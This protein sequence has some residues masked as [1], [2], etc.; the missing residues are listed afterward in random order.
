MT[1]SILPFLG[2]ALALPAGSLAEE[3]HHEHVAPHGGTLVVLGEEFAHVELVL[4]AD[5]GELRAYVLDG[6]A[7]RG[8]RVAQKTL[9][10]RIEA[11]EPGD[12]AGARSELALGAI[13]NVLTGETVGDSSEF[14]IRHP[15]LRGLE[16]FRGE[17]A[18]VVVKGRPFE[19][20]AFDFPEGNEEHAGSAPALAHG[21]KR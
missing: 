3:G 6:E 18:R 20:V 13:A 1:K 16:R 4:D 5:S 2:L 19:A 8:V 14:R 11:G 10:L 9:G 17:I 12:A 7:E 21:G 15:R